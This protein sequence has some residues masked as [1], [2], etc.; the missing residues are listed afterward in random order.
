MEVPLDIFK[1]KKK[2]RIE[3][4]K[5]ILAN[6]QNDIPNH[7]IIKYKNKIDID[8][9]DQIIKH[10]YHVMKRKN[11]DISHFDLYFDK[12]KN[13]ID[14]YKT[15]ENSL[16][17]QEFLDIC[18]IYIKIECIK[19][20]ESIV[21]CKGCNKDLESDEETDDNIYT[22]SSCDCINT[23]LN[24]NSY[25]RITDNFTSIEDDT[26]NFIKV[27][28]KFEGKNEPHPPD[29]IYE[30]LD[31]YFISMKMQNGDYYRNLPLNDKGKKDGTSKKK[32]W[33]AL[34]NTGNNKYYDESN[35]IAH[36]YWGWKLPDIT[37]LR[38]RLI[39][40]YQE[41]ENVWNKIKHNYNRSASLGTQFRL[42]VQLKALN[43]PCEREDFKIQDMVESLR[44]HNHAWK[45]MCNESN[46]QYIFVS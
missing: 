17:L 10:K 24:P 18:N 22:C 7:V 9:L 5:N 31:V 23:F 14:N 36:K 37:L 2:A 12:H 8:K 34:E 11:L 43:Y 35:F 38:E 39:S 40:D 15:T 1:K 41:T 3:I 46:L 4:P 45:I 27:L 44:I 26:S 19:Q 16:F 20:I 13:I 29:I 42:Y 21:R 25:S 6:N 32:L 30:E 33:D 28:D